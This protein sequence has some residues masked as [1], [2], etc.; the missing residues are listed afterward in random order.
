MASAQRRMSEKGL[1][2]TRRRLGMRRPSI[3]TLSS[4]RSQQP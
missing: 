2:D 4:M 3:A 1:T